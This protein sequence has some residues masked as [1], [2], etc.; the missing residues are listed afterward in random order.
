MT[1]EGWRGGPG[2]GRR[3]ARSR[4]PTWTRSSTPAPAPRRARCSTTTRRSRRCCCRCCRIDRSPASAGRT[5]SSATASSRRTPPPVRRAGCA[6]PTCR[7]RDHAARAGTATGSCSRSSTTSRPSPGRPTW[8]PSSSTSTSGRST[9]KGKPRGAD[10]LV[11]DLD[12]GE[13]AGLHECCQVALLVRDK[14]RRARSSTPARSPAAARASISTPTC[15][16][17]RTPTRPS[18]MAKDDRRGAPGRAPEAG[19]RDDDQGQAL[20]QG[21]PRLV[22]ER[23]LQDHGVAV[24]PARSSSARSSPRRSPG[25]RSRRAPRI[26]SASTSSAT[27]RCSRG[28]Q[29]HGDL[30]TE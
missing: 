3:A 26:P 21:L 27:T 19:H 30:F 15:R 11:I 22:A 4:S 2:R 5:A 12:P 1:P 6:P 18:A 20:R 14:L 24:L 28:S 17:G 16:G 10:R 23:R 25:T 8:P 7:P 9:K 29:E 13:R